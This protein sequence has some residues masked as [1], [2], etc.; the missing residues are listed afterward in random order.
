MFLEHSLAT[1]SAGA[2]SCPDCYGS[3]TRTPEIKTLPKRQ[4]LYV[5]WSLCREGEIVQVVA[6]VGTRPVN[7]SLA[8]AADNSPRREPWVWRLKSG[9]PRRGGID[10]ASHDSV[11]QSAAPPGPALY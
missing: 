1:Y 11:S 6:A 3:P 2:G 5:V 4:A 10:S 9:E 8:E 7:G